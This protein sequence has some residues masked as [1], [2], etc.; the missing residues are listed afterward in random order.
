[1]CAANI[2]VYD[3]ARLLKHPLDLFLVVLPPLLVCLQLF[4]LVLPLLRKLRLLGIND[5]SLT[6]Q[7]VAL[8]TEQVLEAEHELLE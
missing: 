7:L 6:F 4:V 2:Q 3:V 8:S 1:M 5:F